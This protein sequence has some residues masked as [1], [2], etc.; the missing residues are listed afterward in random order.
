M[1]VGMARYGVTSKGA[2]G[3]DFLT[4]AAD[5]AVTPIARFVIDM[6]ADV[7]DG[8]G[9]DMVV[10]DDDAYC[11]N[12]VAG[13]TYATGGSVAGGIGIIINED[14]ADDDADDDG[15]NDGARPGTK[16]IALKI[17]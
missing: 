11:A 5:G 12:A 10:D 9:D 7:G 17:F 1:F 3:E 2:T 14:A 4:G 15:V 6:R 8:D 13:T 16:V